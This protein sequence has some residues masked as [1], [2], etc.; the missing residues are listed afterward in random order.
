MR[1]GLR[2]SPIHWPSEERWQ[3]TNSVSSALLINIGP[4]KERS[5][6]QG[7]ERVSKCMLSGVQTTLGSKHI[8]FVLEYILLEVIVSSGINQLGCFDIHPCRM[9]HLL[10]QLYTTSSFSSISL[11]VFITLCNIYL[12]HVNYIAILMQPLLFYYTGCSWTQFSLSTH[13]VLWCSWILTLLNHY[14]IIA[15]FLLFSFQDEIYIYNK[16]RWRMN[17]E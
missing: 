11:G 4:T 13:F 17:L 3:Q 16:L 1:D 14:S 9:Q 10:D 6:K 15:S 7:D 2:Q 5:E 8:L 12:P